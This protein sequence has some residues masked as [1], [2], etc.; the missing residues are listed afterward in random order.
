MFPPFCFHSLRVFFP[1]LFMMTGFS[2]QWECKGSFSRVSDL[3]WLT[4]ETIFTPSQELTNW[5]ET[6]ATHWLH[7]FPA[8]FFQRRE[9][10]SDGQAEADCHQW[11][12][13]AG[14]LVQE[15]KGGF[16]TC[17]HAF[18]EESRDVWSPDTLNICPTWHLTSPNVALSLS[19]SPLSKGSTVCFVTSMSL[20]SATAERLLHKH[21]QENKQFAQEA[22]KFWVTSI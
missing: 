22:Q 19:T 21:K 8:A 14:P 13:S 2:C 17:S 18:R 5:T 15:V 12:I 4:K 20:T 3:I 1:L 16:L 11:Q 6:C 10:I 7:L 9:S